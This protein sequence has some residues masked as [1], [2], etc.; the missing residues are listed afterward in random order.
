MPP[1]LYQPLS[2]QALSEQ[3]GLP[4][5]CDGGFIAQG[6]WLS[7]QQF[8]QNTFD[9]LATR[10]VIIKTQQ[11]ITALE[12]QTTHWLLTTEQ[13]DSF[14]HQVV[15]LANGHK[16]TQ[17]RQTEHLPVYPVRGQVSEIATSTE[18][19]KL[20]AVI[21]YDGYLTPKAASQTHCLGASHLRDNAERTF[22]LQE[23]QENQQKI[24]TNLAS[25][26]WVNE[27]DTRN[28]QARIGIR[29]SVR[30]R[31]PMLG[32]VPDFEQQLSDYHNLYNLRRRKHAIKNAALHPNLFL[33]GALGSRGLTS[34]PL[35]AETLA[36]LIYHEPL[37]L[38][39]DI[40]H[41]LN[42]NRS[43]IRK[44]LKEVK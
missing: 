26:D 39:E 31:I 24:Q 19:S 10:G 23:Q 21:C 28:N 8:V 1:S 33:I 41:Q 17:F 25:V 18:L 20:K 16:L 44:L 7:P 13:G 22:S 30:D 29:C 40:L 6:A 9:F 32:N 3:V 15:V 34:A 36:S 11:K 37:P 43:W 35:L 2:Q 38:S 4:L 5:P 27:V 14:K 42:A 12:R